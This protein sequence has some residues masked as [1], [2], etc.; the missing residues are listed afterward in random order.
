VLNVV[1]NPLRGAA[2]TQFDVVHSTYAR[3]PRVIRRSHLPTVITVHDLTPLRLPEAMVGRAQ[4]AIT[5][6]IIESIRSV[7]HVACVSEATRKD[8]LEHTAHPADKTSVIY[9]GVNH[10]VFRPQT[11]PEILRQT[12][13]K[14]RLGE[15]S[16]VLT[17]SS[18]APHKNLRMLADAW[19]SI[20]PPPDGTLVI[21]GGRTASQPM[22]RKMLGIPESDR[23]IV[24]TGYVTDEEFR[25][26]ASACNAFLFPSLYEGFGLPVLEAMA[27]GAPVIAADC[28]SLPEVVGTAGTLLAPNDRDAWRE[29]I[30]SA[31]AAP[32]RSQ[33]HEPSLERARQFSWDRAAGEYICLYRRLVAADGGRG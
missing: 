3:F 7:D 14:F 18:L 1:R 16:F 31:V 21:A 33:P 4:R 6:R 8:F 11:D 9:N 10:N 32:P 22:V 12:R 26:L 15:G 30:A 28:T 5:R 24:V 13:A 29:A 19:R 23:S 20:Q 25:S 27:A 17:T 2:I